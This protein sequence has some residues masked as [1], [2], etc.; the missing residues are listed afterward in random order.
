M[1]RSVIYPCIL[2]YL[3]QKEYG[4]F[5][6]FRS[7]RQIYNLLVSGR[8]DMVGEAKMDL[9]RKPLFSP[10]VAWISDLASFG[11]V[12]LIGQQSNRMANTIQLYSGYL[13]NQKADAELL[14]SAELIYTRN[15]CKPETGIRFP[16]KRKPL[17][18]TDLSVCC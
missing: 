6:Q 15:F 16:T 8:L 1:K 14:N 7:L 17:T 10:R 11:T 13:L 5:E 12:K 2:F 9:Y 18:E 4:I 3:S